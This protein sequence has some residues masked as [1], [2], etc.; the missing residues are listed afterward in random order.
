[1]PTADAWSGKGSWRR[2]I[3]WRTKRGCLERRV[4]KGS[5]SN[6]CAT[7]HSNDCSF[8]AQRQ[9]L[10]PSRRFRAPFFFRRC[11]LPTLFQPFRRLCW[12]PFL[13][14][15]RLARS[16]FTLR[17]LTFILFPRAFPDYRGNPS[18]LSPLSTAPRAQI[19]EPMR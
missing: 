5:V 19:V 3:F 4:A 12:P 1:M 6:R 11:R 15:S 8:A 10:S 17:E 13:F 18:R 9:G 7:I 14:N 2:R 16:L